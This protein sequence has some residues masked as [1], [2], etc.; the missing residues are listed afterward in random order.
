MSVVFCYRTLRNSSGQ[1]HKLP[2]KQLSVPLQNH[3]LKW[4]ENCALRL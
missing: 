1:I 2:K 3:S 4:R